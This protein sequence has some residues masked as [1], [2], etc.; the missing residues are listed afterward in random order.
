MQFAM[1]PDG[2]ET[3][4]MPGQTFWWKTRRYTMLSNG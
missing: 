1:T 2:R 4:V 3:A